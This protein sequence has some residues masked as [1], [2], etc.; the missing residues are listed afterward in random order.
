MFLVKVNIVDEEVKKP[1]SSYDPHAP[2]TRK[3]VL[4]SLKTGK[5]IEIKEHDTVSFGNY[6]LND[7]VFTVSHALSLLFDIN[8]KV[9]SH[10]NHS[11]LIYF[12]QFGRCRFVT[13][14]EKLNRIGEGTYGIVCKCYKFI[15]LLRLVENT[16]SICFMKFTDRARDTT[17]NEIVALKRVRMDQEKD[18]LPISGLREIQVLKQCDHVNVVKVNEVVV[19]KSLER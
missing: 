10:A 7:L 18:G 3:G 1:I 9:L 5:P 2:I 16:V 11:Y 12:L 19:G 15:N 6:V 14:F 8:R 17:K 4:T 13:E